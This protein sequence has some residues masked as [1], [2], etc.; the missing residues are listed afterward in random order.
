[1]SIGQLKNLLVIE[2]PVLAPDGG[3]GFTVSWQEVAE[4]YADIAELAG[5]EPLQHRQLSSRMPCR[6]TLLY[7]ADIRADMRLTGGGRSYGIVSLRDPD[8]KGAYLEI[9]ASAT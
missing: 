2:E 3:G 4:V 6:I 5:S 9:I 1:M 8:G 7:R